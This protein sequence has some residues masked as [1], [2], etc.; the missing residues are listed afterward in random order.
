MKTKKIQSVLCISVLILFVATSFVSAGEKKDS[1]EKQRK[2]IQKDK[3]EALKELYKL[4]P[5]AKGE[6]ASAKG[7]AIFANTGV[8]L[9]LLST[10]RGGGV[11]HDN[12]TGKD[13]YM[14]MISGGV[15]IGLGVKKYFAIFIFTTSDAFK[16][17][18]DSGWSAETQADAAAKTDTQGEA[19]A[20]GLS[21][22]PGVML[23]QI[24]DVG[25]AA[26]ATIQGTKFIKNEDLN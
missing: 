19:V 6:M 23:Y 26:Q 20:A 22:A 18:T 16:S 25:F 15:G 1:P 12:S 24:T 8:N 9:L 2:E 21:I 7:N 17:F 3:K 11:A 14:K 4:Y 5:S 13:T 10:G